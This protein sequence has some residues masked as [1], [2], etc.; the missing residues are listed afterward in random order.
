MPPVWRAPRPDPRRRRGR[1]A[2]TTTPGNPAPAGSAAGEEGPGSL[3]RTS[4]STS[5]AAPRACNWKIP[6]RPALYLHYDDDAEVWLN[7]RQIATLDYTVSYQM[8]PWTRRP[9]SC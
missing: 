8:I 1:P 6:A 5:V 3:S 7:G 9:P 2:S 4:W